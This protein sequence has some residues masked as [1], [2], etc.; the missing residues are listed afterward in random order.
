MSTILDEEY[1]TIPEAAQLLQV[2]PSSIRRWIDAGDLPAH[3]VG[4]RRVLVKRADLAN[5]ITPARVEPK[6]SQA[7]TQGDA[8][9]HAERLV[10]PKLTPEEQRQALEA[11]ERARKHAAELLRRKGQYRG[12]ESWE[13][14]NEARDERTRQLS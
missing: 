12:P 8:L 5:L 3:R 13:L 6:L 11:L 9:D 7:E 2:H 4:Q 1:V 10:I 14:L